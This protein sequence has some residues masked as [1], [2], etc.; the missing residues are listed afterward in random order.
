MESYISA[1]PLPAVSDRNWALTWKA[2]EGTEL[3][4]VFFFSYFVIE[5]SKLNS[6]CSEITPL[7]TVTHRGDSLDCCKY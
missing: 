6:L 2:S 4:T 5:L 3:E 1:I 7:I